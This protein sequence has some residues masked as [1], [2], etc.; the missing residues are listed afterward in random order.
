L[1]VY[2]DMFGGHQRGTPWPLADF[3][4]SYAAH[5]QLGTEAIFGVLDV[6]A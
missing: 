4:Q 3:V 1:Y 5:D 2:G 6:H